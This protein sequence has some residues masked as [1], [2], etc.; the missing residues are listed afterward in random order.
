MQRINSVVL[1]LSGALL[2]SGCVHKAQK[3]SKVEPAHVEL[4]KETGL[5]HLTLT[6]KAVE[7]LGI[8]TTQV[9]ETGSYKVVPYAAIIYD[10]KGDTWVYTNP[11]PLNFLR[12]QITIDH[13]K[14]NEAVLSQGP[15]VGTEVVTVGV[16]ELYG[17]ESG[18]G[19]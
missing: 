15:M 3:Y 4:N 17:T 12:H 18:V 11:E 9:L 2:L 19:H 10:I 16:A 8:I 1:L 14:G 6:E 5:G 7:R 13:I